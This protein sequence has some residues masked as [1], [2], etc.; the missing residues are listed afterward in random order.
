MRKE[1]VMYQE[2]NEFRQLVRMGSNLEVMI[3]DVKEFGG[4]VINTK[5]LEF[6]AGSLWVYEEMEKRRNRG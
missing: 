4:C 2:Y 6:V 5:T 3:A 1:E